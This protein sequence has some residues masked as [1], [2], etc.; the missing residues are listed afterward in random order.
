M[1]RSREKLK[2][3]SEYFS[4]KSIPQDFSDIIKEELGISLE[5]RYGSH[6]IKSP[7]LI[8]PG[9]LTIHTSQ[10]AKIKKAGYGG[11]VLKSVV[12]EDEKG[13]CSMAY[14]RKPSTYIK[15]VYD[16]DDKEGAFPIIH[17]DGR[18]DTRNLPE[19]SKFARET[20]KHSNPDFLIVAS[21]LCHLPSP[22]EDFRKDEW[23]HTTEKLFNC[24]YGIFEI[25]FC[26]FLKKDS[27]LIEKE[28]ILRWYRTVPRFV[29]SI[30]PRIVV[31][32][33]LLNLDFGLKFQIQMVEASL[34]GKADGIV[35]ANRIFKREYDSGHGGEELR[36]RNL[37]QI[38][39][40]RR[41]F[42]E[43][44]ISATGGVYSGRHVFD[45][46]DAGAENVQI[47]S[48]IMGKVN[49]PFPKDDGNK[50]ERVFHKLMLD[51]QDGLISC[52]LKEVFPQ[53][54]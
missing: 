7:L 37:S 42:P 46:L 33:K 45:Y 40:I 20:Q 32:P 18:C 23:L 2:K 49:S 11:C 44:S 5:S 19:Y 29:K 38:K 31:F 54:C 1:E 52:T 34:E 26:P 4:D 39:E 48:Y 17:W 3:L 6:F 36:Q 14:Q 30:S 50:F 47:L 16:P 51:T 53:L 8:A 10:I 15:T 35:V 41:I 27:I 25:D 21:F 22:N 12:G 24:G 9:Q 28:N 13:A 43:I